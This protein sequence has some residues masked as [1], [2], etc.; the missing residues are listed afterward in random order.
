MIFPRVL[1]RIGNNSDGNTSLG[2]SI[3]NMY[4]TATQVGSWSR[5]ISRPS[6]RKQSDNRCGTFTRHEDGSHLLLTTVSK[7]ERSVLVHYLKFLEKDN[8]KKKLSRLPVKW[9]IFPLS[10]LKTDT[11]T[12]RSISD[13][14]MINITLNTVLRR[15]VDNPDRT[16]PYSTVCS[17]VTMINFSL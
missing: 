5:W 10:L 7:R 2:F 4:K 17:G 9:P 12:C 16:H 6:S 3:T 8:N 1:W 15:T 13:I 14:M 11:I